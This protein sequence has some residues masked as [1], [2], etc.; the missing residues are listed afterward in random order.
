MKNILLTGRPR[1][2]KSTIIQKV[3][4]RLRSTGFTNIG[5]FY[6]SE[7]RKGGEHVG[8]AINTID[9]KVG[10]LAEVGFESPYR[11]GKY[12]IDMEAFERIALAFLEDA[13]SNPKLNGYE[14]CYYLRHCF[15]PTDI[16]YEGQSL[17]SRC[18]TW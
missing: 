7:I 11:L 17:H 8:F 10:R 15:T 13:I 6:T 18:R 14:L 2:G 12:G 3:V 1:V 4:E 9:G 16:Q 5:G